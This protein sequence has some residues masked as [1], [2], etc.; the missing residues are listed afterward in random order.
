MLTR[1]GDAVAELLTWVMLAMSIVGMG[2]CVAG[3]ILIVRLW[4]AI[5]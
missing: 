5:F 1:L 3:I 4:P 2:V